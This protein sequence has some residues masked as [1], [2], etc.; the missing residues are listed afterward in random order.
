MDWLISQGTLLYI[1][2]MKKNQKHF[3]TGADVGTY[4]VQVL[5]PFVFFCLAL[6]DPHWPIKKLGYL[7]IH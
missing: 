1:T 3:Q 2:G 5:L 7:C 6:I 4:S